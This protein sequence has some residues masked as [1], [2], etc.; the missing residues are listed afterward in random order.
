[1][2]SA[3]ASAKPNPVLPAGI[4][5]QWIEACSTWG[6]GQCQNKTYPPNVIDA[7]VEPEAIQASDYADDN[8]TR[9]EVLKMAFKFFVCACGLGIALATC[10]R[11]HAWFY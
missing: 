2:A 1:M 6:C 8:Y 7:L 11:I 10:G 5:D 4:Q 9:A 3:V